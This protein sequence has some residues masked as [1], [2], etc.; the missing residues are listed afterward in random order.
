MGQR[1]TPNLVSCISRRQ[2]LLSGS[3]AAAVALLD[4]RDLLAQTQGLQKEI[5][6]LRGMLQ[7]VRKEG[8]GTAVTVET[9]RGKLRVLMGAGGN[10]AILPGRDGKLL[11]DAGYAALRRKIVDA[12][13]GISAD[14]I[15]HVINT[16][17]HFDHADG[18]EWL[19]SAGATIHAHENTRKRLSTATRVAD[20]DTTFS[21]SPGG[22]IPTEV[23]ATERTLDLNGMQ[24]ALTPIAPAHT[25]GD[26]I[27]RFTGADVIHLGDTFWNGYYPFIDYS[28]VGSIDGMIRSTEANLAQI[29]DKTIVIPG[30]GP[31]GGKPELTNYRDLL[32]AV[33]EKVATLKKQGKS[34]AEVVAAKPT[35]AY[36]AKWG[37]GFTSPVMFTHLVYQ[38]V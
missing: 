19:H 25:D 5:A 12:L 2:F 8:E 22:A 29:T 10:I 27:V 1:M 33:R 24:I 11:I 38:G 23:Y 3:L 30:H 34:F 32:V 37:G 20:W 13:A 6:R 7:K 26:L 18:N 31:V 35:A 28:T 14:P 16:H 21:P 9:L 36:D 17:W 15:K 4:P